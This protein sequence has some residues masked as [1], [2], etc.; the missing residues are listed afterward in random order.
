MAVAPVDWIEQ[1]FLT[2]RA[3]CEIWRDGANSFGVSAFDDLESRHS[4]ADSER[5]F[6]NIDSRNCG[7]L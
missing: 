4:L 1:F 2:I 7:K 3:D 6:H 5:F